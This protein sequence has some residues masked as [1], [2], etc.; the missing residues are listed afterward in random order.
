VDKITVVST[1]DGRTSGASQITGEMAKMVAQ[2]PEL[3]ETLTGT[4]VSDLLGRLR[5]IEARPAMT[6]PANGATGATGG[7]GTPPAETKATS[8]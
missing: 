6:A 3:L 1:G 8:T 5:A 4:K 2:V 7:P